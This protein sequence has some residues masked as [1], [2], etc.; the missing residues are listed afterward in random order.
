MRVNEAG[1]SIRVVRASR[2]IAATIVIALV[3]SASLAQAPRHAELPNFY[4]VSE[5]LY[6]GGQ[7]KTGA[8]RS[9]PRLE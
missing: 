2:M 6:R 3:A 5:R 9:S 4:K 7:P 8:S 1:F